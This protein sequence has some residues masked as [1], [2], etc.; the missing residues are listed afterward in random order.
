MKLNKKSLSK[1]LMLTAAL[2]LVTI[3]TVAVLTSCSSSDDS[4]NDKPKPTTKYKTTLVYDSTTAFGG[5]YII[6]DS[7]KTKIMDCDELTIVP[8]SA[9]DPDHNIMFLPPW[10]NNAD[11]IDIVHLEINGMSSIKTGTLP[12][13]TSTL[14]IIGDGLDS[15]DLSYCPNLA[16]LTIDAFFLA[17]LDLPNTPN[18]T[19][20][21]FRGY[22]NCLDLANCTNLTS[23]SLTDTFSYIHDKGYHMDLSPLTNLTSLDLNVS[24]SSLDLSGCTN[25]TSL[26]II[27]IEYLTTSLDLSH[28]TKLTSV[29]INAPHLTSLDISNLSKLNMLDFSYCQSLTTIA[30]LPN[31]T[32]DITV[33]YNGR[34][35]AYDVNSLKS[36][37]HITL[38]DPFTLVD[39]TN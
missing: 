14:S 38:V 18:L 27:S 10:L 13:N 19:S 21:D 29:S 25:L 32:H 33:K 9:I 6:P 28:N 16:S 22:T 35:T 20:L 24:A 31:I 37:S 1:L 7:E 26:S 23:L 39:T 4:N 17:S 15:L 30:G 2:S 3:P 11:S 5:G 36:N 34:N 8:P 12:E